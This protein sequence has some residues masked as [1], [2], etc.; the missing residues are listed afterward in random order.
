MFVVLPTRLE[1]DSVALR[2]NIELL[3]CLRQEG[4]TYVCRCDSCATEL[5]RDKKGALKRTQHY[6]NAK[7]VMQAVR[8]GKL[9]RE[10]QTLDP[11]E[12]R[13]KPGRVKQCAYCEKQYVDTTK[14]NVGTMCSR[15]CAN[16]KM[17]ATRKA[18]GSF[19]PTEEQNKRR[20]A[21]MKQKHAEGHYKDVLTPD[22]LEKAHAALRGRK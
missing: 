21:T 12:A 4:D 18:N 11:E 5:R 2:L 19:T 20:S 15:A 1:A 7:C 9:T 3:V 10:T 22:I 6:C 17:V 8:D 14:R 13:Q 16:A